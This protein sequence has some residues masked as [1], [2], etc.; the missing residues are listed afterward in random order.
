M[1]GSVQSAG[2]VN[3]VHVL[4]EQAT[5]VAEVIAEAGRRGVRCVEPTAEAEAAWGDVIRAKSV[6]LYTFQSECTPGYYNAEGMPRPRSESYGDG[7][8][9][10]YEL[11]RRWRAEGG[12]DEVLGS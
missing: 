10:F 5:H 1:L 6:D 2:S 11:I 9:A 3:Y 8:I 4:D 12:M 7:P